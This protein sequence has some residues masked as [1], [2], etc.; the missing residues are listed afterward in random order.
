MI[1]MAYV[2]DENEKFEIDYS[3]EEIWA[4]IPQVVKDLDWAIE[5]SDEDAHRA[6]IKS[7]RG[8]LAY[9]TAIAIELKSSGEKKTRMS[10]SGETPVTTITSIL[11]FGRT[12]DRIGL[13]IATLAKKLEKKPKSKE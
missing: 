12:R 4:A 9:S 2:R 11:D 6:K 5:E 13:F 8:F 3:L 7:R 10:I 1:K